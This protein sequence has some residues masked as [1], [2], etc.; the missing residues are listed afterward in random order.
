MIAY[1]HVALIGLGLISSSIALALRR[2]G[3]EGRITGTARSAATRAEAK[4]LGFCD[5]IVDTNIDA[6]KDAD[7]VILCTPVGAMGAITEEIAPHLKPGATITDVGSVKIDVI[8]A[9]QPH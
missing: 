2:A 5:A 3:Y 6:V 9:V 1:K 7:L 4:A 8:N